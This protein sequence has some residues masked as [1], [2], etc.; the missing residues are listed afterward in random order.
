MGMG[1][2]VVLPRDGVLEPTHVGCYDE[3][4]SGVSRITLSRRGRRG[5]LP[6]WVIDGW[7]RWEW[8]GE[9]KG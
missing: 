1:G 6:R 2:L 3:V 9:E 8:G 4:A 7:D 5:A